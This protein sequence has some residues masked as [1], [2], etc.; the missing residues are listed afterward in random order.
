M[1]L[2]AAEKLGVPRGSLF[3]IGD[4]HE[5]QNL[6]AVRVLSLLM[7]GNGREKLEARGEK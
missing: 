5:Q 7:V 2:N 4:L 3:S 1:Y 6:S